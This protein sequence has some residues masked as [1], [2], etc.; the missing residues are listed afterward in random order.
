[1]APPVHPA[2]GGSRLVLVAGRDPIRTASG[3][4]SYVVAHA[5]SA[6]L[7]GYE[8][9]IFS[10]ARRTETVLTDA[11]WLH[12]VRSPVRPLR[13]ITCM[14]QRPWLVDPICRLLGD[15]PGPHLLHAFGTWADIAIAVAGR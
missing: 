14:L 3:F 5:R 8:P 13:S 2:R 6:I 7:A 11:G 15:A 12:R 9:H 4:G 1:M 10:A